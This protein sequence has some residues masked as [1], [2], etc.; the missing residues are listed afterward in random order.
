MQSVLTCISMENKEKAFSPS[1]SFLNRK[2][3]VDLTKNRLAKYKG[4]NIIKKCKNHFG[5][6]WLCSIKELRMI[7]IGLNPEYVGKL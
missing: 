2:G 6:D 4:N 7:G 5:V 1:S 3:R